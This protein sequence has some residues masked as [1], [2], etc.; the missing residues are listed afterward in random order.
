LTPEEEARK[1]IDKML[2]G[3][4]WKVQT[5]SETNLHA[6]PGVAI[7]EFPLKSGHGFADYLLYVDGRAVGV[8]EAKPEGSTLTGVEV[9]TGKYSTGLPDE[10]PAPVRPLPF[11]YQSTGV[12]TRFTNLLDP[13]ARSRRVY[14]FHRPETF[15]EW[16]TAGRLPG[17]DRPSALRGRVRH[18]PP[19]VTTGLWP[20]QT[21]AVE[22]LEKSL[23]EDRPRSLIQMATGSGKTFTAITAAYRLVKFADARRVLFLVDRAN[24]GRQALKE[25]QQYVTPDDGRKFTE[26]YNVQL[27][28]SNKIDPVARVV[29]TTIQRLYSILRGD[30]ELDPALEEGSQFSTGAGLLNEPVPIQYNPNVPPELFDVVFIDECHRSIYTL[31]RQVL[32]YYD[33][34]LIGLTATPGKQTFG[35]FNQNLVMEYNHEQA[36]ADGVNVDFDVYRI[37]TEITKKGSIIQAGLW[38]DKRN[39]ETRAVTLQRLDE[40]LTYGADSLD[41]DVVAKDQIRRVVRTFKERLPTEIFPGRAEVP[42]TLI[43]AKDDSHAEDIVEIVREEFGKGNEFCQKITYKTTGAKPEDLIQAFR[44][45]FNPR[46]AVTVDMI[47]TGTD[48]RPLEIVMFLRAVKSRTFFEQMKGR[49]VRVISPS[50]LRAVSGEDATVKD[51]FVIVD[52]VGACESELSDTFSLDREPT[53]SLEKV[54]KQVGFGA[55]GETLAGTLAGKLSRLDRRLSEEQR[56]AIR[57]ASGGPSLKEITGGIVK[58]LDPDSHIEAAR[59]KLKLPAGTTPPPEAVKEAKEELLRVALT[60]LAA[61]PALRE[62]ILEVKKR[63]EQVIDNVS[64]DHLI[65]AGFSA[66]AKARAKTVVKDFEEF[67]REHKDEITALQVLYAKPHAKRLTFEDVKA[68]ADAIGAP[69]RQWTPEVLWRAYETLERDKVK[70]ASQRRLLTDIVSLVRFALKQEE[71]LEPFPEHVKERFEDWIRGQEGGGRKFTPEQREWLELMRDH[72]AGS[73]AIDAEAFEYAPFSQ[74]GGLGRASVVFG[75]DLTKVITELNEVL[76][77]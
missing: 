32:E 23:A 30:P 2:I 34:F 8:I 67:I 61:N 45:S 72:I 66:D 58:A 41:R 27:L 38:V 76:A 70:G 12:E 22:N 56:G 35:F 9:Q 20:A 77:E 3:S 44:N 68:L 46:I 75:K 55:A 6:G 73:L 63:A 47:A 57:E 39:R 11:L 7:R 33:A 64:Q 74:K 53:A 59:A 65:E 21:R 24:L 60:P 54:L 15:R 31:W 48:I 42:K 29:I 16:L 4:G 51:R 37:L 50:D 14:S 36:V 5:V 69:P 18:M 17:S 28:T 71:V 49:G 52:C 40:P 13:E 62:K 25:F 19:L 10:V 43:Y 26:L 1:Q